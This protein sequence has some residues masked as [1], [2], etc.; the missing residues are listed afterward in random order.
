MLLKIKLCYDWHSIDLFILDARVGF[1]NAQIFW[2]ISKY[3]HE[4]SSSY[5]GLSNNIHIYTQT[6]RK[7]KTH[8]NKFNQIN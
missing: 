3:I 4:H 8:V 7:T 2:F 5:D 1:V 6:K